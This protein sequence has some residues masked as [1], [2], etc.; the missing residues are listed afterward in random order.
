MKEIRLDLLI[1]RHYARSALLSILTIGILLLAMYFGINA[2]IGRQTELTLK[3]EVRAVLPDFVS[4][5][6]DS[7]HS[8]FAFIARQTAHFASAHEEIF[9]HPD[10]V[11]PAG[12]KP[13]F[14]RAANGSLYQTNIKDGSSLFIAATGKTGAREIL[15]AEDLPKVMTAGFT[16]KRGGHGLG[17]HSFAVFLSASNGRLRVESDGKGKGTRVIVEM[18]NE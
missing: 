3:R 4:Q 9:A 7:I 11:A 2:Y 15:K 6:A 10:G 18:K 13:Q 5:T 1:F 8:N 17:L 14:E 12:K 16:T